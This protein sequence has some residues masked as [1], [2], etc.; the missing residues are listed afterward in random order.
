MEIQRDIHIDRQTDRQ[1]DANSVPHTQTD[2]MQQDQY[3]HDIAIA[4]HLHDRSVLDNFQ[5][6]GDALFEIVE[7]LD[8]EGDSLIS[9]D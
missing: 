1:T 3:I 9:D 5:L 8:L 7:D 2:S 6:N 4:N